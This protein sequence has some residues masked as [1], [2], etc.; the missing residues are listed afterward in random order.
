MLNIGDI[1]FVRG[2][3][4]SPVDDAIKLGEAILDKTKF[5]CNF[6]HVAVYVG[7]NRVAEAQG[8]RKSGYGRIGQYANNYDIGHVREMTA[9]QRIQF[10]QALNTENG[11]PY[12][13]PG[14]FWLAAKILTGYDHKYREHRRRYCSKYI[15]WALW[16]AGITV[17]DRTP[18]DLALDS[19]VTIERGSVSM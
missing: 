17:N 7:G 19:R 18:E 6:V 14:I 2:E 16:K 15:G 9:E 1:V 4:T 8:L 13:W 5:A 3:F 10:L 11:L 12:D